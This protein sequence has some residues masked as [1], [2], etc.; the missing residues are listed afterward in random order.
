MGLIVTGLG[1]AVLFQFVIL[2]YKWNKGLY[3]DA[4]IDIAMLMILNT[5]FGGS[6]LGVVSATA[7][8]TLISLWLI[9]FPI[10]S[11]AWPDFSDGATPKV[12]QDSLD[13]KIDKACDS[14][15][16]AIDKLLK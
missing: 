9:K 1:L 5:I 13:T 2:R 15:D 10:K 11:V 16:K 8:S 7:G 12:K 14:L 6:Q 3:L 4:V